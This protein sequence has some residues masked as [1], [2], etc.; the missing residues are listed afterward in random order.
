M[1]FLGF[2]SN[3]LSVSFI[4][5]FAGIISAPIM[6]YKSTYY[7]KNILKN[8][9]GQVFSLIST[10]GSFLYSIGGIFIGTLASFFSQEKIGYLLITTSILLII[11]SLTII[12]INCQKYKITKYQYIFY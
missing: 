5:V 3:W 8:I 10:V 2:Q 12:I 9:Q 7:Q 1:F 4:L 11:L 6:I